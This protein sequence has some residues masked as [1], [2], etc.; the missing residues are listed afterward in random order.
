MRERVSWDRDEPSLNW[1]TAR[2]SNPSSFPRW[3]ERREDLFPLLPV[4]ELLPLLQHL[5]HQLIGLGVA[6]VF[7]LLGRGRS[8]CRIRAAR[9][10]FLHPRIGAAVVGGI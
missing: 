10:G 6:V 1:N 7:V 4:Q 8:C 3:R 5:L 9:L 2:R